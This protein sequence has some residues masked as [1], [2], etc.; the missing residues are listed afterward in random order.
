MLRVLPYQEGNLRPMGSVEVREQKTP[1]TAGAIGA[2]PVKILTNITLYG[3]II[4]ENMDIQF[5]FF[6]DY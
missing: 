1:Y 2:I 3:K 6:D 5:P 4:Y